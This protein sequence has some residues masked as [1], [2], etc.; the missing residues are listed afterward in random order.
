MILAGK[1]QDIIPWHWFQVILIILNVVVVLYML[2]YLYKAMRKFYGQGRFKTFI[3][4]LI[5]SI[6]AMIVNLVLL[7]LFTLISAISI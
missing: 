1:L 6:L 4:Y 2:I 7:V 5:V 3:K